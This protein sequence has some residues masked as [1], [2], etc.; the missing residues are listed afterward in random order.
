MSRPRRIDKKAVARARKA[1]AQARSLD[2]LRAAQAVLLPA[3]MDTTLTET[4]ALLGVGRATVAPRRSRRMTHLCSD[5]VTHTENRI[6]RAPLTVGWWYRHHPRRRRVS[7]EMNKFRLCLRCPW[8][9]AQFVA[10]A[11]SCRQ[12]PS[13][14]SALVIKVGSFPTSAEAMIFRV[15][16]LY[17]GRA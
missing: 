2:E 12:R 1:V 8:N 7:K 4:A 10:R 15:F 16:S 13:G 17:T 11:K 5:K 6:W 14:G 3:V 9:L